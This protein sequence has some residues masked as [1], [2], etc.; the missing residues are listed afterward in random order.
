LYRTLLCRAALRLHS[1]YHGRDF[2][3]NDPV[4]LYYEI[5]PAA[6]PE[7]FWSSVER[8]EVGQ[9]QDGWTLPQPRVRFV[10]TDARLDWFNTQLG[11]V[12]KQR[13]IDAEL[14]WV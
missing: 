1:F 7:V 9:G 14:R 6:D 10:E 4:D 2:P 8:G 12:E 11:N 5:K 3:A 13:V